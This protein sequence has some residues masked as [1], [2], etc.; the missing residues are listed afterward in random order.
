M[1]DIEKA[2]KQFKRWEECGWSKSEVPNTYMLILAKQSLEKQLNN[3]WIP[4]NDRLPECKGQVLTCDKNGNVH[5]F[6]HDDYYKYPFGISPDDMCY[7]MPIAWQLL[8]EPY[9]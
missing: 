7:Y 6:Y 2:I 5:V 1:N 9:K 8:P 4:V 3:N